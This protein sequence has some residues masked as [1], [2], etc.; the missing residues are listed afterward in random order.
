MRGGRAAAA[1]AASRNNKAQ[2]AG[3]SFKRKK[4]NNDASSNQS[5]GSLEEIEREVS[6]LGLDDVDQDEVSDT[7]QPTTHVQGRNSRLTT[8]KSHD[9]QQQKGRN[10]EA[11]IANSNSHVAYSKRN[12][13]DDI[14]LNES[15]VSLTGL[16][17][18]PI[19]V[20]ELNLDETELQNFNATTDGRRP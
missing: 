8:Q 1:H 16:T 11:F 12:Q 9:P 4:K 10:E 7:L 2:N 15:Q 17:K 6:E 3:P 5:V 19:R 18:D 20:G 13:P 14:S